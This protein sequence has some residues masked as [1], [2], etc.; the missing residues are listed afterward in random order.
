MGHNFIS[1]KIFSSFISYFL[2][3]EYKQTFASIFTEQF[4]E[5]CEQ[6]SPC[7]ILREYCVNTGHTDVNDYTKILPASH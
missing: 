5:N 1:L 2:L 4:A 3:H 7:C 6:F